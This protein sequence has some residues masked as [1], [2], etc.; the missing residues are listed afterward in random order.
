MPRTTSHAFRVLFGSIVCSLLA[1]NVA[2]APTPN[3]RSNSF[4]T[5]NF[6]SLVAR[7]PAPISFPLG[8][9]GQDGS[10][11]ASIA[12]GASGKKFNVVVDNGSP[13]F[14]LLSETSEQLVRPSSSSTF[15]AY[16]ANGWGMQYDEKSTAVGFVAQDKLTIGG[17]S[18]DDMPFG[19]AKTVTGLLVN[20]FEDG[21][22]GFPPRTRSPTRLP[23][24]L[25]VFAANSLIPAMISGW[26]LPRRAD[27][28]GGGEVMLGGTN[29]AKFDASTLVEVD[30]VDATG[31]H[32]KVSVSAVKID[33]KA[34]ISTE[35]TAQV[36]TGTSD[37]R[38][39]PA[40]SRALLMKIPG[41]QFLAAGS[42]EEDNQEGSQ[43]GTN[44]EYVLPCNTESKL[45]FTI[46]G[47]D[48]DVD[49]R[50]LALGARGLPDNV[51]LSHIFGDPG[52]NEDEIFLGA[53][54][55]KNVY[56]SLNLDT[57]KVGLAMPK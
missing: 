11:F 16:E 49:P 10:Y 15:K 46:G 21:I 32:W 52:L 39:N 1:V 30:N 55:L 24:I 38:A 56:L 7:A 37:I 40:I 31:N 53:A 19:V 26:R 35:L 34:V 27:G 29:P 33:G 4:T 12:M 47:K 42:D 54:F 36:D 2:A 28:G 22:M 6:T 5:S 14:W 23:A 8:I 45:A 3:S 9:S 50:D 57:N 13:V 25:E 17:V 44:G 18:L 20:A 51:C 41:V 43:K 48:W